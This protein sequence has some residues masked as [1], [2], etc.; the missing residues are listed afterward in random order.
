[1]A[2][3]DSIMI[4]PRGFEDIGCTCDE[5]SGANPARTGHCAG[6]RQL[7][8]LTLAVKRGNQDGKKG[9]KLYCSEECADKKGAK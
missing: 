4:R 1:M 9:E 5:C 8:D 7:F 3:G 2:F 6:C